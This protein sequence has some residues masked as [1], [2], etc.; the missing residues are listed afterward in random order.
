MLQQRKPV[1]SKLLSTYYPPLLLITALIKILPYKRLPKQCC[2]VTIQHFFFA[3]SS[4]PLISALLIASKPLYYT[5]FCGGWFSIYPDT[6]KCF[7]VNT[8]FYGPFLG[9]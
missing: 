6:D 7:K 2:L 4:G 5:I 8:L 1:S 9:D 3:P